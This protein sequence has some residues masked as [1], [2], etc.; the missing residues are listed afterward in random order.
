[1]IRGDQGDQFDSLSHDM[2]QKKAED[3]DLS[4]RVKKRQDWVGLA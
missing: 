4:S 3:E 1:V 2:E